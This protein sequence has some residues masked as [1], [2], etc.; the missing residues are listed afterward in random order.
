MGRVEGFGIRKR[1]EEM[2]WF[3]QLTSVAYRLLAL[4]DH[5]RITSGASEKQSV[6]FYGE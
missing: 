3:E 4:A 6:A 1:A 2:K 5:S